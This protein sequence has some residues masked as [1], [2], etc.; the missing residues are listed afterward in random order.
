VSSLSSDSITLGYDR[1][2]AEWQMADHAVGME[3]ELAELVARLH[4]AERWHQDAEVARL[5]REVT[6]LVEDLAQATEPAPAP[7]PVFHGVERAA[8]QPGGGGPARAA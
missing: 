6:R 5:R 4:E 7:A 3:L 2:M 8:G 1:T